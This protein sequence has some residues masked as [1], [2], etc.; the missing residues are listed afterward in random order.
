MV[1]NKEHLFLSTEVVRVL[2]KIVA[3][4]KEIK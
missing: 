2:E 1:M 4:E 3:L